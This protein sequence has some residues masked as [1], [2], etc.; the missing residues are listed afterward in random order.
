MLSYI[1][2]GSFTDQGIRSVKDTTKRADAAKEA[3]KRFGVKMNDI[4]WTQ[5]QYDLGSREPNIQ[6]WNVNAR[7]DRS[8]TLRHTRHN[9]RPLDN[10][11]EEVVKHVARLW[12]FRVRLE[13]V[14]SHDRVLQHWEVTPAPQHH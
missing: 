5:G 13:S 2:L 8:L 9:D 7:G 6:V 10:G 12:G 1:V 4:Y 3:A 14:D 11:A